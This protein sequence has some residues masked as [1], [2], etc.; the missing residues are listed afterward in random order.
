MSEDDA[1][2]SEEQDDSDVVIEF[3]SSQT[4]DSGDD[5]SDVPFAGGDERTATVDEQVQFICS[6]QTDFFEHGARVGLQA[7][8]A[9]SVSTMPRVCSSQSCAPSKNDDGCRSWRSLPLVG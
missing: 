6:C 5:G 7:A 8:K 4:E 2:Q 1:P 3:A 9:C